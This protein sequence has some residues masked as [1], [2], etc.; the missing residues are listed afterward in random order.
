MQDLCLLDQK[1]QLIITTEFSYWPTGIDLLHI[2]MTFKSLSVN[3]IFSSKFKSF[4]TVS[5]WVSSFF[6][7][8]FFLLLLLLLP[9]NWLKWRHH[10]YKLLQGHCTT[11]C[12]QSLI[13]KWLQKKC[14]FELLPER[15]EWRCSS[16][17]RWQGVPCPCSWHRECSITQRWTTAHQHIKGQ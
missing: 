12:R 3:N 17:V 2:N 14:L 9:K 11:H 7:F 1:V 15:G 16:N 4:S 13:R 5:E 8:F 6:F 10:S